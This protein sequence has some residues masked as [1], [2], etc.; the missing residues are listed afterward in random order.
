MLFRTIDF[1]STKS[2]GTLIAVA[3]VGMIAVCSGKNES[4]SASAPP[5][6]VV[7]TAAEMCSS[8]IGMTIPASA[9]GLPTSGATVASA[10]LVSATDAGN[11]SG[12]H[13]KVL[14]NIRPVDFDAPDIRVE[15]DLPTNF[16][17][18]SVHFGGGGFDGSIPNVSGHP[19]DG[20]I[21]EAEPAG[22]DTPLR[23]GYVTYGSDGGHSGT[24]FDG[25]F[26]ANDEALLNYSGN[27]IKKTHDFAAY[28]TKARYGSNA[29]LNYFIGGSNGGRQGLIAAQRYPKDY[30]GIIST[31]PASAITGLWL[32]MG[33]ISKAFLS[34]GGYVSADKGKAILSAV[35][36]QC[37]ALDGVA[38]GIVSN[39]SACVF[40]PKSLRCPDGADTSNSCL[41]DA[42]LN[43]LTIAGTPLR[44]DFDLANGIRTFP[45]F[46]LSSGLDFWT[47][48]P[49][50]AS[51]TEAVIQPGAYEKSSLFYTFSNDMLRF[52]IAR[53][54]SLS[55]LAF[56]PESPGPLT[57]RIQ[58]VGAQMD[59]TTTD[60]TQF[61]NRGGKLI[62][63]HAVGDQFIPY[64]LAIDY[65]KGLVS[66]FGQGQL[67]QFVKFYAAPGAAHGGGGQFNG[68]YDGLTALD[69]WVAKGTE[70]KN[71]KITDLTPA[72]AGRT[73]PLCEYPLWPKYI[74]GAQNEASSFVC[75][76]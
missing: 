52:A 1:W 11:V 20:F 47:A 31:F 8:F 18:K 39:P 59:S 44:T 37:D 7:K 57:E 13:C 29:K 68:S 48:M 35:M 75:S 54:P 10:K 64:Q 55:I 14:G 19:Y 30:D 17:G 16:N 42:Q 67:N 2:V 58:T 3:S 51:A 34:P 12:E 23:R 65:Y 50:G 26:A 21:Y 27:H 28:I 40:D 46:N 49:W 62:L 70:P 63:Q 32:Q 74:G 25:N 72:T 9:I 15:V 66:R 33:R 61:Q 73:R 56:N 6:P 71:L 69:N 22:V 24:Y 4:D 38:D 76:N 36:R 45:G 43:T 60:L 41:S 5:Q 53:D